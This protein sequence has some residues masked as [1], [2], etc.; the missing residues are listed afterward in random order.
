M[1]AAVDVPRSTS[2]RS[3]IRA[4]TREGCTHQYVLPPSFLG[5]DAV[6]RP[7]RWGSRVFFFFSPIF[8]Y[9]YVPPLLL[10][11]CLFS[12]LRPTSVPRRVSLSWAPWRCHD[13]ER[14]NGAS[15]L[16]K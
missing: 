16:R 8:K 11:F 9:R 7:A 13:V 15:G 1:L 12:G 14:Y 5:E 6:G 3:M 4:D 10:F 2:N